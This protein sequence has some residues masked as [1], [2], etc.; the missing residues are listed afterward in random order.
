MLV[1]PLDNIFLF[2]KDFVIDPIKIGAIFP[3]STRLAKAMLNNLRIE[4]GDAVVELGPGTGAFT[5]MIS[6][7]TSVYLG[8][9]QNFRFSK[10]LHQRFPELLF[11]H[12]LAEECHLHY[13]KVGFPLPKVI[14]CGLPVSLWSEKMQES[15]LEVL[16]ELMDQN[17]I[18]RM[19]QYAHSFIIPSAFRFRKKMKARFGPYTR[20]PV[21]L[22]NLPP[23]FILTWKRI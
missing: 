13:P 20:S 11:I 4:E 19:F 14:I 5:S 21:V 12:G 18:F 17:C 7:K 3:S 8:I 9:E 16:E 6:K 10:L 23:A 2:M 15:L 22:G 1:Q